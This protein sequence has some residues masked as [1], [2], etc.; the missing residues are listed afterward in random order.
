MTIF[1][2]LHPKIYHHCPKEF[3]ASASGFLPT[4]IRTLLPKQHSITLSKKPHHPTTQA[5]FPAPQKTNPR[6]RTNIGN[7]KTYSMFHS[8]GNIRP[9]FNN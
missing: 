3:Y 9:G 8:D 4:F 1:V 5:T 2:H 7:P 6:T